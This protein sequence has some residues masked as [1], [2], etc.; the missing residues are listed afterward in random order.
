METSQA[1]VPNERC[2]CGSS[3]FCDTHTHRIVE[4]RDVGTGK[5][6]L[7]DTSQDC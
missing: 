2:T 5:C 1:R 4:C 6:Q 3:C 7:F